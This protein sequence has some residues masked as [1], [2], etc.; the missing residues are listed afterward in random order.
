MIRILLASSAALARETIATKNVALTIE[1][2]YGSFVAE[3]KLYTAAHHQPAGSPY[4]GTHIGGAMPSPCNDHNIP[5]AGRIVA[6]GNAF[7]LV[8]HIDLDTFGGCFR[9]TGWDSLF[10]DAF[11]PFWDL[12]E[13]VDTRGAHKLPESG[14][15]DV[16]KARLYAFWAWS[17]TN[18]PRFPRDT[19]ADVTSLVNSAAGAIASIL[20]GDTARLAQ[21]EQFRLDGEA[22][23]GRTFRSRIGSVIIR[24]A[25]EFCNDLYIDPS[26]DVALAVASLNTKTGAMTI[27]LADPIEGVS[28]RALMQK[29]YGPEAGGHDGI[30]GTPREKRYSEHD[31]SDLAIALDAIL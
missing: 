12:A 11:Q 1:A 10:V 4:A 20:H 15:S 27:S 26:G 21:G 30:A 19:I 5:S 14:A 25:G 6:T 8:S 3:G 2:E 13:F 17:R 18:S 31:V 16:D 24:V 22:R 9:A 28:C 23:N 29:L 7:I